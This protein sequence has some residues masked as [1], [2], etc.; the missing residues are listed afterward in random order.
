M[1]RSVPIANEAEFQKWLAQVLE[2]QR[3]RLREMAAQNEAQSHAGAKALER[4]AVQENQ[5]EGSRDF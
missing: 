1:E 4:V 2:S 3:T 5:N